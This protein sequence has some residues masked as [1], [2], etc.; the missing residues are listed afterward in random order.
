MEKI[1]KINDDKSLS[2]DEKNK[3]LGPLRETVN[4]SY[5]VPAQKLVESLSS[6]KTATEKQIAHFSDL[7]EKAKKEGNTEQVQKLQ[8]SIRGYQEHLETVAQELTQAEFE[9]DNAAKTGKGVKTNQGTVL[10]LGT[11]DK[12]ADKALAQYMRNQMDSAVYQRTLPD[13]TPMMDFEGKPIIGP[14]QLK[15]QLNLQKASTASSLEKMSEKERAAAIAAL[16]KAREQDAAAAERAGKRTANAS[17]RAA[18]REERAQQKLAAGYQKALD[19]ADQL[20]GQMGESSKATVSFDQSLR[21]VTKSLTDLAN[22][23]PNEF[24][25]Q[26]MVDQAKKRLADLRN[27]TPNTVKCLIAATSSK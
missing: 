9:R 12:G 7:L 13:G 14:K 20:M 11:S 25:S 4:K 3:L 17:E 26:E 8:G 22:A 10:G 15:T 16:T 23:T 6:R 19:K 2:D 1:Q 24:I 27:A 18:K 21:D 5:L